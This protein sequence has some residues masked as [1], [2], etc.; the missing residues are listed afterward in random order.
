MVEAKSKYFLESA[1]LRISSLRF[2]RLP[3]TLPVLNMTTEA[4]TAIHFERSLNWFDANRQK[5][6]K[7][8]IVAAIGAL[9]VSYYVWSSNQQET[10]A[11]AA[12]SDV[13]PGAG[14]ADDYLKLASQYPKTTAA[15]R[16]VLLAA[17]D[18]FATG[19]YTEAQA[20]FERLLRDYTDSPFRVPALLGVAASLD[21]QGNIAEAT[22]RY[23]DIIQRYSKD[24][25]TAQ[26]KSALA[27]LHEIAGKPALAL[28]LYEDLQKTEA[29]NSFGLEANIRRL[30]LL[31]KYPE[32]AKATAPVVS[33]K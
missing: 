11:S 22:T 3:G 1:Q 25:A 19:K 32:L 26:A 27:R 8:A 30:A 20:Q 28:A 7:I 4:P 24:A 2:G 31:A 15:P 33:P 29:Y 13:K 23:S 5:L 6:I 16:A 21:A 12:L 14:A 18:L 10:N 17:G 9:V